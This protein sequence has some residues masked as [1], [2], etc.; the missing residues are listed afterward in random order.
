MFFR[1]QKTAGNDNR[2]APVEGHECC[3][4]TVIAAGTRL[5]GSID[6]DGE[7]RVDGAIRGHVRAV[8]LTVGD[9]GVIEG[10]ADADEVHVAGHVKG[11]IR[12]RHVHLGRGS[13]VE[14]DIV[15]ATIAI[16][17]GARLS[18]AVWQ[19]QAPAAQPHRA[20]QSGDALLESIEKETF[21]PL[22]VVRPRA[23]SLR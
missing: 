12:A 2:I 18:G 23:G 7:L 4:E 16:D 9:D 3:P 19:E 13:R 10:E 20:G 11:P 6:C 17:T 5:E 21:R 15:S 1:K 22:A 14:G 8:R